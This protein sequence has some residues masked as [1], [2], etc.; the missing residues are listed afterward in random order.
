MLLGLDD[1]VQRVPHDLPLGGGVRVGQA[2]A[3]RARLVDDEED[4]RRHPEDIGHPIRLAKED[5]DPHLENFDVILR[6]DLSRDEGRE[7]RL[8]YSTL[9]FAGSK[10]T[11]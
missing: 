9:I 11:G 4:V 6:R 1:L 10:Q 2:L 3:H 7:P 8:H 5:V